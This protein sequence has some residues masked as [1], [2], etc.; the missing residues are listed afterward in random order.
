MNIRRNCL[1]ACSILYLGAIVSC[2]TVEGLGRDMQAVG[3]SIQKSSQAASSSNSAKPSTSPEQP[4]APVSTP[5]SGA[6]GALV[7]PIK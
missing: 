4:V 7:T 2:S 5:D 3:S 6:A 1:L